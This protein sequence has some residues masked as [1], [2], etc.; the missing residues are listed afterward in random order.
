MRPLSGRPGGLTETTI[1]ATILELNRIWV[2]NK[3]VFSGNK[4]QQMIFP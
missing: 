4:V 1:G 3:N 2:A